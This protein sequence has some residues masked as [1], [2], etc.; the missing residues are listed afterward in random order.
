MT[1]SSTTPSGEMPGGTPVIARTTTKPAITV[2]MP[3]P[4]ER[5]LTTLNVRALASED[6]ARIKS[7]TIKGSG[8]YR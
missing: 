8:E 1:K 2:P 7:R 3:I 6:T 4:M 5:I